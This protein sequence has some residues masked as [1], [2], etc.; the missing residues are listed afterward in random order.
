MHQAGQAVELA[1]QAFG[2]LQHPHAAGAGA[3]QQ[4][5]QLDVGERLGAVGEQLFARAGGAGQFL[6]RHGGGRGG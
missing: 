4:R 2:E 3:Q 6:D 1:Q 5:Q